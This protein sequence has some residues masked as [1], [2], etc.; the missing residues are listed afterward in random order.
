MKKKKT[1]AAPPSWLVSNCFSNLFIFAPPHLWLLILPRPG[2][3]GP[4]GAHFKP[5]APAGRGLPAATREPHPTNDLSLVE[6]ILVE[7]AFW[8]F[9][10]VLHTFGHFL[11]K[12]TPF[13]NVV[14][15][16]RIFF[17]QK[18]FFAEIFSSTHSSMKFRADS[19]SG[20][21]SPPRPN[22]G[23]LFFL[24]CCQFLALF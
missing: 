6:W 18:L 23:I 14:L 15:S 22:P 11:D 5:M 4:I 7:D 10:V 1:P 17:D 19:D 9:W 24:I 2:P 16:G 3:S 12:K 21:D 20:I 13:Q 8:S